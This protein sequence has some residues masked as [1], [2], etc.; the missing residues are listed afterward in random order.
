MSA[1]IDLTDRNFGKLKV[2]GID[3]KEKTKYGSKFIGA[4]SVNA[5]TKLWL[6]GHA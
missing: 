2:I 4:A 5:E 6:V 3:H 1:L